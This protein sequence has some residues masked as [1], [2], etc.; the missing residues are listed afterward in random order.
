MPSKLLISI[1][2][3][4]V[5]AREAVAGLIRS[6]GFL[7][8]GFKSAFDFLNSEI[9]SRTDCLISDVR[10]PEMSGIALFRILNASD[11][12]IPTILM[13]AYADESA[14]RAALALGIVCY[15]SKPLNADVLLDCIH[16]AL[17]G[18]AGGS[19]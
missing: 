16:L 19:N 18:A 9:R 10:M 6:F 2:D 11:R 8:A 13:T 17:G 1:V 12:P 3:D 5:S 14:R 15:L 4:D 7:A